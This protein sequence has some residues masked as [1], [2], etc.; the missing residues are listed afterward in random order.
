MIEKII[1]D[2]LLEALNVDVYLEKPDN[3]PERY[4]L[5]EK[6]SNSKEN[7]I[8]TATFAVQSYAE[9]LFFAAELN[10]V[11]INAMDNLVKLKEIGSS[12]YNTDYN[13]TDTSK[14]IYRY[15]AI[16]DVTY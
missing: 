5:I 6:T 15:Q 4:V 3:P 13:Y 16:Y 11:V 7:H 12:K 1:L 9:S 14:K 2:Y 8:Y 10:G